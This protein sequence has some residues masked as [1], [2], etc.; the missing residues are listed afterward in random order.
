LRPIGE[1]EEGG[2]DYGQLT[3]GQEHSCQASISTTKS[4]TA[5]LWYDRV[6]PV[7]FWA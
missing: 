1:T 3:P 2:E 4:I 7:K 6:C 5:V